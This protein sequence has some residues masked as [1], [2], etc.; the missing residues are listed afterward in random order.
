[1]VHDVDAPDGV[2]LNGY[3]GMARDDDDDE[4]EEE[5]DD[6]EEDEMEKEVVDDYE[7]NGK[8]PQTISQREMVNTLADDADTMV[9]DQR[10][11]LPEKGQE[12]RQHTPQPQPPAAAPQPQTLHP[13]P[14]PRT[15][16]TYTLSGLELLGLGTAEKQCLDDAPPDV[17]L[18]DPSPDRSLGK[19]HTSSRILVLS[20]SFA[21]TYSSQGLIQARVE[22][23]CPFGLELWACSFPFF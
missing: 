19:Q 9:D 7:D 22:V 2:Y 12:M 16:V 6:K 10:T 4:D 3:V 14:Q 11:M 18:P 20:V 17:P 13:C 5:E 1:M 15:P 23:F 8:E 21:V